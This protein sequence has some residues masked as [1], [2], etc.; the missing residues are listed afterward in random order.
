MFRAKAT[1][2]HLVSFTK[3]LSKIEVEER[4]NKA[5]KAKIY[6]GWK[7]EGRFIYRQRI[8]QIN[9]RSIKY[10]GPLIKKKNNR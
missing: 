1:N 2:P 5:A 6:C 4:R 7:S 10:L 9:Y 3:I 8:I